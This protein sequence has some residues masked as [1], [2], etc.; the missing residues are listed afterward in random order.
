MLKPYKTSTEPWAFS[1]MTRAVTQKVALHNEDE[2]MYQHEGTHTNNFALLKYNLAIRNGD[3]ALTILATYPFS[4]LQMAM[5]LI[6]D[7]TGGIVSKHRTSSLEGEKHTSNIISLKNDMASFIEEPRIQ[8]GMYTLEILIPKA[9][10]LPS[11]E[12]KTCLNF[13]L[14]VEYVSRTHGQNAEHD[15]LYDIIAIKPFG[16]KNMW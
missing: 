8:A 1:G 4:E 9:A 5:R 11:K 6:D 14:V 13:D 7:R 15:G 10:F 2:T 3:N 16:D 12:H